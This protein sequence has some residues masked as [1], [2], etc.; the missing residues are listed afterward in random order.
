GPF[1]PQAK[2]LVCPPKGYSEAL[3]P[4]EYVTQY[5]NRYLIYKLGNYSPRRFQIMAMRVGNDLGVARAGKPRVIL[6]KAKIGKSVAEAPDIYR[7]GNGRVHL[8]LSRNGYKDC[9]YATQVWSGKGLWS[10]K[11]PKWVTGMGPNSK[12]CGPGGAEVIKDG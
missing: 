6:S 5:N 1:V 7:S 4:G 11:N 9:D 10:L 12:F 3:D 2:P 8:F